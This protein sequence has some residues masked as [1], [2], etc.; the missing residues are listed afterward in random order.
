MNYQW[1]KFKENYSPKI[2]GKYRKS[3]ENEFVIGILHI[4][5]SLNEA[6]FF[7]VLIKN[8]HEMLWHLS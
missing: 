3:L 1:N 6:Y 8:C 4:I 7:Y 2:L 5:L